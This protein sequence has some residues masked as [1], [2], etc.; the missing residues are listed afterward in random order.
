MSKN[1]EKW[2][3]YM[4]DNDSPNE[5]QDKLYE[6]RKQ[7]M[8][9]KE[10]LRSLTKALHDKCSYVDSLENDLE[11]AILRI[12]QINACQEKFA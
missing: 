12:N 9:L 1:N 6:Q 8:Q 10:R 11:H 4:S 5:V 2:S 3:E 7:I